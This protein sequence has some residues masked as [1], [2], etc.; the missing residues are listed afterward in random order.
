MKTG[1]FVVNTARAQLI[2]GEALLA[3]LDAGKIA[4]AA[5]D[6][7]ENEPNC[8]WRLAQHHRVIATP[9]IGGF[10]QESVDRAMTAAV[11]NLLRALREE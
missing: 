8:D 10:T 9:H 2:D 3:A 11:E 4:G 5:L 1:A 7:F 6:V